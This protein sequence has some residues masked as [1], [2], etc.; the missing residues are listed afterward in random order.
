MTNSLNQKNILLIISGGIAA[1]KTLELIRILKRNGATVSCVMTAAA[2][3]FITTLSVKTLSEN[4]VHH[5]LFQKNQNPMTHIQL[6]RDADLIIAAPATANLIAKTAQ[7]LAD[8]LATTLLLAANKPIL[9]APAMNPEMW[10]AAATQRNIKR[11]RQDKHLFIGPEMGDAACGETGLGR[12]SEPETIAE[13]AET[14]LREKDRRNPPPILKGLKA[15]VTSG[16]TREALDPV[17]YISNRSSGKQ[18]H[19]IAKALAAMGAETLLVSGPC[20]AETPSMA[21]FQNIESAAQMHEACEAALPVDVAVCVA[22]ICDWRP[23]SQ[24]RDKIKK[25][26]A[27]PQLELEETPDI[28]Q[29]LSRKRKTRPKLVIGFA[30]ETDNLLRHAE[31]KRRRKGCDWIL[32]NDVSPEGGVLGGD[33]NEVHLIREEGAAGAAS[34]KRMSKEAVAEKL[35]FAIAAHFGRDLRS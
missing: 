20:S 33:Y 11:L 23:R 4:P 14:I 3:N 18:G 12:M 5:K 21:R 7:G 15:L 29:C 34:W 22:A 28:L 17:R 30:A 26:K 10:S 25:H 6:A 27:R 1:Y 2:K 31:Q 8:D 19:A 24:A 9:L 16:P 35:G 13:K 32:A